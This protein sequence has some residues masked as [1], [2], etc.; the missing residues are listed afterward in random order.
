MACGMG[1]HAAPLHPSLAGV[2]PLLSLPGTCSCRLCF[3]RATTKL[4]ESI[5]LTSSIPP[6][7][8]YD[9]ALPPGPVDSASTARDRPGTVTAAAHNTLT[10]TPAPTT[11]TGV[12]NHQNEGFPPPQNAQQRP[13]TSTACPPPP[14]LLLAQAGASPARCM[15]AGWSLIATGAGTILISVPP[16]RSVTPAPQKTTMVVGSQRKPPAWA[17]NPIV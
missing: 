9:A 12:K 7:M 10:G 1:G 16:A 8:T 13:H 11:G 5:V 2:R 17:E 6:T 14:R 3:L 15:H 4:T